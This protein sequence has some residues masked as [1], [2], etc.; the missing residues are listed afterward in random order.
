MS[1]RLRS[2]NQLIYFLR[3]LPDTMYVTDMAALDTEF[4]FTQSGNAEIQ[5]EWY[6]LA[7]RNNYR[8][9]DP[10]IEKFLVEVGR[11]KFLRP[12]YGEMIKTPAG[13]EWAK[14]IYIKA[15]PNY[16]PV[17]YNTIDAMLK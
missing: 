13:K 4:K 5:T 11:R 12:L 1:Q 9:A 2:T 8:A 17:A 15:R 7:I 6:V 16:H 14:R 10:Y 3:G